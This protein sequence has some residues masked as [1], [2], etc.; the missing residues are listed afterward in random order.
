MMSILFFC[1]K[2]GQVAFCSL[3]LIFARDDSISEQ[4][5][6]NLQR[7]LIIREDIS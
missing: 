5:K 4:A 1:E 3:H 6:L 7:G 2:N